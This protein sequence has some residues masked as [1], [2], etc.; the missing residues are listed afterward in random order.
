ME[1]LAAFELERLLHRAAAERFERVRCGW[2]AA[3]GA[4]PSVWDAS[5]LQ[6]EPDAPAPTLDEAVELAELPARWYPELRHRQIYVAGTAEGRE[7][8]FSLARRDWHVNELWL[9]VSRQPPRRVPPGAARIDGPQMR[10]L[11]G[12]LGVEQGLEPDNVAEFDRYDALRA[13]VG[14]RL[15]HAGVANGTAVALADLYLRGDIAVIEDVATLR[16]FRGRGHGS[17]AVLS[18]TAAAFRVSAR[19]VYLFA[20]PEVAQGFYEPLGFERI[21]TAYDCQRAPEGEHGQWRE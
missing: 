5:R 6:V 4:L 16:R 14:A 2:V 17:A 19:A 7:L 15:T 1:V 13:R 10:R 9:M 21:F 3:N 11:K 18:A 8:A 12:R 20:A